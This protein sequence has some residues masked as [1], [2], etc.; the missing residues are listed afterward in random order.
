MAQEIPA[1]RGGGDLTLGD[2]DDD[3]DFG[4]DNDDG[5]A[6]EEGIWMTI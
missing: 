3:L 6:G 2:D 1:Q 4:D 5:A